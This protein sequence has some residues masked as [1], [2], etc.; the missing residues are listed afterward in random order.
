MVIAQLFARI[1]GFLAQFVRDERSIIPFLLIVAFLAGCLCMQVAYLLLGRRK[2][3]ARITSLIEEAAYRKGEAEH[4]R[5]KLLSD[6]LN[7]HFLFNNLSAL[8]TL[9]EE[10]RRA[11]LKF[12]DELAAVY[13]HVLKIYRTR[14]SSL[15]EEISFLDNYYQLL[16]IR[17]G[18]NLQLSIDIPADQGGWQIPPLTLQLLLENAVK[19]NVITNEKPLYVFVRLE[20]D[21]LVVE[22]NVQAKTAS[23]FSSKIGLQQIRERYRLLEAGEIEVEH[24]GTIFRVTVPLVSCK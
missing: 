19:H 12:V 1:P 10:D 4:F 16:Q 13:R 9:I 3:E 21:K 15:E 17:Y 7:P 11:A 22:N 23:L 6:Q 18:K 8:S 2:Q 20:K 14:L 5:A 24:T